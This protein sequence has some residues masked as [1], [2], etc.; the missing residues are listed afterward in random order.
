MERALSVTDVLN[1]KHESFDF[2][3][4]WLDAFD[5]PERRGVWFIWGNSGNGKSTFALKLAKYLTNFGKVA[6]NSLEEGKSKTIKKA[7]KMVGMEEV[8]GRL[9][10]INDDMESLKERLSK[11]RSSD[12]VFIDSLQYTGLNMK[13]YFEF[14]RLFPHKLLVFTSHAK[15]KQPSTKTAEGVMYDSDLKIW[16]EGYKAITKG[17]YIGS[18]GELII[19]NSGAELYWGT[20]KQQQ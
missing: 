9:I 18:N 7:F 4:E 11:Q 6:Y 19:W 14:K 13:R 15:G 1:L 5:R 8:Q 2:E 3:G 17:R 20:K 12:I 10:L 16:I